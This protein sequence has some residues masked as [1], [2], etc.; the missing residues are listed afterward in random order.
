MER[1]ECWQF[2]IIDLNFK[3][4]LWNNKFEDMENAILLILLLLSIF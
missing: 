3:Q 1:V 2:A 4:T